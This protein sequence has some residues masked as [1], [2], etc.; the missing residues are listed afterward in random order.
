MEAGL[1]NLYYPSQERGFRKTAENWG[2]QIEAACL[3]NII[4]EFWPDIRHKL[5]RQK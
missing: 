5:L 3:N 4:R 1:S 2:T